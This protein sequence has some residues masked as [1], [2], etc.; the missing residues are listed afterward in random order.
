V[1][2]TVYQDP[3]VQIDSVPPALTPNQNRPPAA[4]VAGVRKRSVPIPGVREAWH[5]VLG[6]ITPDAMEQLL[7]ISNSREVAAGQSVWSRRDVARGMQLLVRGDVGLGVAVVGAAFQNERGVHAPAWL[8]ATS[9]WLGQAYGTDA[10]A[11]TDVRIVSV[12][13]SAFQAVMERHGELAQ[14]LI[15]ALAVQAR[16][17]ADALHDLTHKDADAR[18]AAWLL[19]RGVADA[20]APSRLRVVLRERKRD[21]AGT[22]GVTPETLS[23]L[24]RQLCRDGLIEVHGYQ[25]SVLDPQALRVRSGVERGTSRAEQQ[26]LRRDRC[27]EYLGL[28][29]GDAGNPDRT[30]QSR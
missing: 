25:I 6:P 29:A 18:L 10:L 5:A 20:A 22:L 2:V 21:L 1:R 26:E 28:L 24:L 27:G 19:Q 4:A 13:R 8:D 9:A 15:V 11:L 14:R 23:R 7:V 12:S 3:D 16:A 30:G 17:L